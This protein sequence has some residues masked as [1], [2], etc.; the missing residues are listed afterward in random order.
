MW[1][2]E[3]IRWSLYA[4][5]Q[6][7]AYSLSESSR[8]SEYSGDGAIGNSEALLVDLTNKAVNSAVLLLLI[9]LLPCAEIAAPATRA[10]IGF[11]QGRDFKSFFWTSAQKKPKPNKTPNIAPDHWH[12]SAEIDLAFSAALIWS[13][14]RLKKSRT[15]NDITQLI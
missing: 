12:N 4:G 10:E 2:S 6:F 3:S 7:T 1:K 8:R 14:I 11:H 5:N 13:S 9:T 15:K